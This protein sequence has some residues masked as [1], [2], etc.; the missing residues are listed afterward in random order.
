M[1]YSSELGP[2]LPTG[3]ENRLF[4]PFI[5][6]FVEKYADPISLHIVDGKHTYSPDRDKDWSNVPRHQM[7]RMLTLIGLGNAI[8]R[9]NFPDLDKI[10]M[11]GGVANYNRRA[12][13]HPQ[14]FTPKEIH[15]LARARQKIDVPE[16]WIIA[17]GPEFLL[18]HKLRPKEVTFTEKLLFFVSDIVMEDRVVDFET[19]LAE[20]SKRQGKLNKDPI[21]LLV[22]KKPYW[23]YELELMRNVH[24]TLIIPALLRNRKSLEL[25]ENLPALIALELNELSAANKNKSIT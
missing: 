15:D 24:D 25:C 4:C 21:Y 1:K 2:Y 22:L 5:E 17:Q 8:G 9:G 23:Q 10:V 7:T 19:R 20:V 18:K 13:T 12:I 6:Q 11:A 14:E 16:D 3:I